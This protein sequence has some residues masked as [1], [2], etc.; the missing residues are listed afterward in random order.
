MA[1][2]MAYIREAQARLVLALQVKRGDRSVNDTVSH[3]VS[4]GLKREEENKN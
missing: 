4:E 2:I 3:L 1:G